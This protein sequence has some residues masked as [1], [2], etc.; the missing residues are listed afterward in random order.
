MAAACACFHLR[1]AARAVT[2]RYDARLASIGLRATQLT[3]LSAV[4]L[5]GELHLTGLADVLAIEQ[6]ALSR[7]VALLKRRKLLRAEAGADRRTQRLVLTR[8]GRVAIE[9]AFPIWQE[10][11]REI[12]ER[13]MP[14]A[15]ERALA[16]VHDLGDAAPKPRKKRASAVYG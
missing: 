16:A 14:V 4:N 6:S 10:L 5:R 7:T 9:R 8:A 1:R 15:L 11:Q 3:V 2:R 13:T 12:E